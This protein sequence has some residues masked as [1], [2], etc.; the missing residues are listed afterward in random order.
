LLGQ[1]TLDAHPCGGEKILNEFQCQTR[2]A[3]IQSLCH[4]RILMPQAPNDIHDDAPI[5]N[6]LVHSSKLRLIIKETSE[7][8]HASFPLALFLI[9]SIMYISGPVNAV[10]LK[11]TEQSL[12]SM[13]ASI[14]AFPIHL[15]SG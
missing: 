6:H 10:V 3:L 15:S 12:P 5:R 11:S 13:K 2:V 14:L 8:V 1:T 7:E 4:G 9:Q